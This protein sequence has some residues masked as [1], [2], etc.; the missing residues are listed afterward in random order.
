MRFSSSR[1]MALAVISSAFLLAA[2][3]CSKSNNN[4][5]NGSMTASINGTAWTANALISGQF[6]VASGGFQIGG[7][8]LKSGDSIVLEVSFYSPVALDQTISSDSTGI[9]I[10]CDKADSLFDG[11]PL[12]GHSTLT[13]TSYDSIGY[14]VGGTFS[15]VLYNISGG[16]DS[17]VVTNGTFST[18]LVPD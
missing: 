5:S 7:L 12:A 11:G 16:S 8:Q 10:E 2:A 15:G 1:A 13:I 17:L 18:S 6:S 9:D 3:S 4:S 14:K